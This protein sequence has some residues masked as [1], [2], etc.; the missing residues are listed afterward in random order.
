MMTSDIQPLAIGIAISVTVGAVCYAM[1]EKEG[2]VKGI[3]SCPCGKVKGKLSAP[4]STPTAACHCEDCVEFLK[5][6]RV[7]RKSPVSVSFSV[8]FFLCVVKYRIYL[9][10][11]VFLLS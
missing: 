10:A 4:T 1:H 2:K 11:V 3:L 7:N 8:F 5:W 6:S 9:L